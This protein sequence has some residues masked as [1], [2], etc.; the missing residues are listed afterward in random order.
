MIFESRMFSKLFLLLFLALAFIS[1]ENIYADTISLE[2][3]DDAFVLTDL[4][5]DN[6]PAIEKINTGNLKYL[7]VGFVT[8]STESP[9]LIISAAFSRP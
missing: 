1:V 8:N 4:D 7:K 5:D 3:T 9:S 2:P 6:L